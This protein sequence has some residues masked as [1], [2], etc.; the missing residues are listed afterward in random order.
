M[1]I[2]KGKFYGVSYLD[3][4]IK[5]TKPKVVVTQEKYGVT[6]YYDNV[7]YE[8]AKKNLLFNIVKQQNLRNIK[9]LLQMS[10]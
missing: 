6:A 8:G 4:Y 2:G 10:I 1:I 9:L 3:Y 5:P 7:L